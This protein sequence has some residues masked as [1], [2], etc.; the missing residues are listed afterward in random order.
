MSSRRGY[1][2]QF[3]GQVV[4]HHRTKRIYL[5]ADQPPRGHDIKATIAFGI[6]EDSFLRAAPIVEQYHGFGGLAFVGYDNFVVKI[7]IPRFKEILLYWAF[8]LF[9]SFAPCKDESVGRIP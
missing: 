3:P 2:L 9:S 5:V 7:K 1:H 6:A 8:A 4:S